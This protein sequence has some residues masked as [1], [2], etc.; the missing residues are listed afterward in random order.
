MIR[1]DFGGDPSALYL[2]VQASNIKLWGNWPTLLVKRYWLSP[3]SAMTLLSS[4]ND[5]ETNESL[6][7]NILK[8]VFSD[9]ILGIGSLI[10][11]RYCCAYFGFTC[12][13]VFY[14]K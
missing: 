2:A 3:K 7:N 1:L 13:S 9:P 11:D 12:N 5:R 4:T 8:A 10:I 6:A 14:I